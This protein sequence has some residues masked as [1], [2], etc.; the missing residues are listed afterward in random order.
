MNRFTDVGTDLK[1]ALVLQTAMDVSPFPNPQS[2]ELTGKREQLEQAVAEPGTVDDPNP[3]FDAV[4][5]TFC[6]A[7]KDPAFHGKADKWLPAYVAR[8]VR[9]EQEAPGSAILRW[10][11]NKVAEKGSVYA[12]GWK[13]RVRL[14]LSVAC[15]E[16]MRG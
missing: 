7:L 15:D 4:I 6:S 12:L 16:R 9:N 10:G 2:L 11:T 14:S 5:S 3:A 13:D 1:T 8:V